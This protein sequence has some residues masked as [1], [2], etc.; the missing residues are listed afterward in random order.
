MR[1]FF[2]ASLCRCSRLFYYPQRRSP[3]APFVLTFIYRHFFQAYTLITPRNSKVPY[4]KHFP[5]ANESAVWG[6]GRQKGSCVVS[7]H[8]NVI[9]C[10]MKCWVKY[11]WRKK[12]SATS[13]RVR[14]KLLQVLISQ[15]SSRIFERISSKNT[16]STNFVKNVALIRVREQ[17]GLIFRRYQMSFFNSNIAAQSNSL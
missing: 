9:E 8:N 16:F 17:K 14:M 15:N 4:G 3:A 6:E 13:V 2:A 10:W 11:Y 7:R 12:K 1:A 5:C